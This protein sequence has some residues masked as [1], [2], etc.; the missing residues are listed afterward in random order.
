MLCH[1]IVSYLPFYSYA[2]IDECEDGLDNCNIYANC[3]DNT[4]SFD[5]ACISGFSGDGVNCTSK[6]FL[7]VLQYCILFPD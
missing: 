7:I 1:Q 5:C 6:W 3:T 4:G 2:D